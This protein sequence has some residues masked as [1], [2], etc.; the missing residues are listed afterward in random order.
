MG[1][2]AGAIYFHSL[3]LSG[4]TTLTGCC[5]EIFRVLTMI[6]ECLYR[7]CFHSLTLSGPVEADR[8]GFG[9][10]HAFCHD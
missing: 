10:Y 9:K 8:L 1:P 6:E 4:L 2:D 3:T 5:I 7:R